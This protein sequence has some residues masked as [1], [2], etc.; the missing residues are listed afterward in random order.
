MGLVPD[1][2][3]Q[4]IA[5]FLDFCYLARQSSLDEGDL[6]AMEDAL[7][8][9]EDCRSIFVETGVRP[10]GISIPRLHSLKHYVSHIQD[11]G[12]PNGLCSSITE[13]KHIHTVKSPWRRS[14]HHEALGQMLLTNQRLDKLAY[15]EATHAGM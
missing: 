6:T 9:W 14:N 15:F 11:F 5:A 3:V 4:A 2:M 7:Q 13:S 8:R 1:R 10:Y 12:V